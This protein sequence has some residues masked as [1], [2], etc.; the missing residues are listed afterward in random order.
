MTTQQKLPRDFLGRICFVIHVAVMA[1]VLSGWAFRFGLAI[2]LIFVP[3]MVLHWQFNRATC[4]LNNLESFLRD[5]HWRDPG[6]REE[7]A[8]LH[9]LIVDVTGIGLSQAMADR[10]IYTL[11]VFLWGLGWWHW[12]GWAGL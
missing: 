5:G 6:N 10:L 8:W 1:Y 9:C 2:Y 3:M 11:L 12:Y 7:G 4:I